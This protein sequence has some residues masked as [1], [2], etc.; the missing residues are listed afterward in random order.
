MVSGACVGV[1]SVLC[2]S[3]ESGCVSVACAF[4]RG[5]CLTLVWL[6]FSLVCRDPLWCASWSLVCSVARVCFGVLVLGSPDAVSPPVV[7]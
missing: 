1:V 4:G 7:G 5:V 3:G 6:V 2:V